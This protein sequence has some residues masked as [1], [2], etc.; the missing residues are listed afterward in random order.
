[1]INNK[2]KVEIKSKNE[3]SE[4]DIKKR[5]HLFGHFKGKVFFEM[6]EFRKYL[7]Y[8]TLWGI[9]PFRN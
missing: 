5:C 1:M 6:Q 9:Y 8:I 7:S 3:K 4:R 2:I